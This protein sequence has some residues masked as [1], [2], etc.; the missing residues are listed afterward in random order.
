MYILTVRV[1]LN[2]HVF[3]KKHFSTRSVHVLI[4]FTLCNY[5][6]KILST[7]LNRPSRE[8]DDLFNVITTAG[9]L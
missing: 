8:M 6:A 7:L 9:Y 4:T 3:E 2:E 1:F 5:T